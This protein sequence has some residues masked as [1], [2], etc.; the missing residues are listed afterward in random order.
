MRVSESPA[1]Y[2]LG[3]STGA[4]PKLEQ[5]EGWIA[6]LNILRWIDRTA[7]RLGIPL[8][9]VD[10]A[11]LSRTEKR[12]VIDSLRLTNIFAADES[13]GHGQTEHKCLSE[14]EF[15]S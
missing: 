4:A 7:R 5:I 15:Q 8:S 1:W 11:I 6:P 10:R 2:S 14:G 12:L 9:T 13:T 3:L